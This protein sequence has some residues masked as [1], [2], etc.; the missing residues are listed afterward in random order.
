METLAALSCGLGV[1]SRI[2]Q[3]INKM[4]V[5]FNTLML[6]RIVDCLSILIWQRTVDGTKGRN[7]PKSLVEELMSNHE[8]DIEGF[9]SAEEFEAAMKRFEA[10]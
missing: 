9:D 4:N 7:R 10:L 8:S 5:S 3:R 6:A 1:N 2:S